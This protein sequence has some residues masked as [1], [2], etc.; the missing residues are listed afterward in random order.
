MEQVFSPLSNNVAWQNGHWCQV[1]DISVSILDLGLV[2]ADATYDVMSFINHQGFRLS[3]HIDRFL[4]S[5]AHSRISI[6]RTAAELLNLVTEAH[7]R[8]G[9]KNSIVWISATRGVPATGNTRDFLNC[10]TNLIVY[11]KPYQL[12]NGTNRVTVCVSQQL[13]IPDVYLDQRHKNFV[14]ADLTRAQWEAIDRGF[15]TAVLLSSDGYLTEGPG[16]NVGIIENNQ[17]LAPRKNCLGGVSMQHLADC[18]DQ[19]GIKFAWSDIDQDQLL[20]CQDMF[21]TT[22][23]GNIVSVTKFEDRVFDQSPI[24]KQ[25]INYINQEIN[26]E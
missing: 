11:V 6:D 26:N 22:T 7:Q 15:D 13:R 16:F 23:I 20:R 21:L 1:K 10:R 4:N 12:F 17:V 14:W 8:S 9:L 24:Q 19:L 5:C 2:H 25:L 18:C 3:D